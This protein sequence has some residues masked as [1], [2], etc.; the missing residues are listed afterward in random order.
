MPKL[1]KYGDKTLHRETIDEVEALFRNPEFRDMVARNLQIMREHCKQ[2][3][4]MD[5]ERKT[6]IEFKLK[7]LIDKKTLEYN[8]AVFTASVGSPALPTLS[9]DYACAVNNGVP[10]YNIE[11]PDNPQQLTFRDFEEDEAVAADGK[12]A[13]IKG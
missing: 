1:I 12:S 3:P 11:A 7:P 4:L 8:R 10:Y 5:Q 6:K 13:A 2:Y 9:I